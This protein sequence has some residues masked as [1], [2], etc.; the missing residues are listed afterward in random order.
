MRLEIDM[1][2]VSN[3]DAIVVREF[4][5]QT[6]QEWVGVIDGGQTEEDGEKVVEHIS[7]YTRQKWINDVLCSHPDGDHIGGLFTVVKKI[8]VG[9]LWVHDPTGHIDMS[10]V[11]AGLRWRHDAAA[12]KVEK[13]MR[14]CADF[15]ELVDS[16]RIPRGEPFA[17]VTV[18]RLFILGPT[19]NYYRELLTEFS[20]IEG[21]FIEDERAD[22]ESVFVRMSESANPDA[23][24]DEDDTTSAEN[25]SSVISRIIYD[26]MTLLF[27]GDASVQALER[28]IVPYGVRDI[29]WLDAPHHGSKH[30]VNSQILDRLMPQVAYFSARGTRKHPSQAVINSLKRRGCTCFSTHKSG[31]LLYGLTAAPRPN[32]GPAEPL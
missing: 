25:N 16:R 15:I 1:L 27:T 5:P 4:N 8:R 20:K 30:N 18:G 28:A 23:V 14:Q 17:G 21:V 26:G 11:R 13:S 3:G 32:W 19:R 29:D 22:E 6:G 31:G 10:Q 24:I 9:R 2:D 7:R 12:G